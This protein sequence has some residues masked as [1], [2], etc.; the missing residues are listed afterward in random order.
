MSFEPQ[1]RRYAGKLLFQYRVMVAGG[2]PT[3]YL[4]E[5]RIFIFRTVG[6]EAALAAAKERG[7]G[8][9]RSYTNADGNPVHHEFVG[10][11]Q[12]LM[13]D[14]V[15]DEDEVWYELIERVKP[16]ERRDKLLLPEAKLDAIRYRDQDA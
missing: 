10:V 5:E 13:I 15:C 12:L 8:L 14:P 2:P 3:R 9:E 11:I 7:R 16:M 1:L 6:P 4:C